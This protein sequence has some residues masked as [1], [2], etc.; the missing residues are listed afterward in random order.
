ML[1]SSKIEGN[2][3]FLHRE[4]EFFFS[5]LPHHTADFHPERVMLENGA[6]IDSLWNRL[7]FPEWRKVWPRG[8]ALVMDVKLMDWVFSARGL[9]GGK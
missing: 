4:R 1:Q 2:K 3:S 7:F 9:R 8:R 5:P 6:E